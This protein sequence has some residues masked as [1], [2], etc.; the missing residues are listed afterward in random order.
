MIW[1]QR[2]IVA[3]NDFLDLLEISAEFGEEDDNKLF[4]WVKSLHLDDE[5]GNPDP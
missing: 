3:E 5:D 1:R 2:P 4:Q